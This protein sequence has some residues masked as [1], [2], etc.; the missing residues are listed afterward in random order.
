LLF[1]ITIEDISLLLEKQNFQ[2][3]LSSIP[4]ILNYGGIEKC[5]NTASLDRI[6]NKIGYIINNVQWV[7]KDVNWMKQDFDQP[8]FISLCI[9]IAHRNQDE[10]KLHISN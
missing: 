1:N 5:T 3:A 2:C 9:A 4:I 6:D 10:Y 7:H 8:Y